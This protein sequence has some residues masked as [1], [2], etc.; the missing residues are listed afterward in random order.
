MPGDCNIYGG[1]QT[2][3]ASE[4]S[5]YWGDIKGDISYQTDLKNILDS[6]VDKESGKSLTSNDFTDVLKQKLERI[7]TIYEITFL[8]KNWETL[9]NNIYT[10]TVAIQG[11][12]ETDAA[13]ADLI[14]SDD[15]ATRTL[16][17]EV[18]SNIIKIEINKGNIK[19]FL[20]GEIPEIALNARILI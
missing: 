16:E 3:K 15:L 9:E 11:I 14:V 1:F 10:Q 20:Q 7:K 2:E 13:I 6:K 8:P 5:T 19:A 12:K 17:L 4:N 18:W